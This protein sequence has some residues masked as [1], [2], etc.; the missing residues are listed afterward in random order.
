MKGRP[1]CLKE[2]NFAYKTDGH[3]TRSGK[4][5]IA[6]EKALTRTETKNGAE[7]GTRTPTGIR[8][9]DPESS[10][11]TNSA[12]S[13][14]KQRKAIDPKAFSPYLTNSTLSRSAKG[15]FEK[16]RRRSDR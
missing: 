5:K 9:L 3:N 7:A 14:Q 16:I 4:K 8:L 1:K 15:V 2:G 13:A 10:A 12:T 6:K 11:S